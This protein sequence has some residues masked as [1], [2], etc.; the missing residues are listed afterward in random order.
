MSFGSTSQGLLTLRIAGE[1]D[2][3]LSRQRARQIASGLGFDEQDQT[4]IATAVSEIARNAWEYAHGGSVAFALEAAKP[5]QASKGPLFSVSI[6]DSGS[7]ILDLAGVLD[8]RFQSQTGMGLGLSGARR[9]MDHFDIESS[10]GGTVVVLG[11]FLPPGVPA[12]DG[13][14][15]AH[16]TSELSSQSPQSLLDEVQRQNQ[17][18][19]RTLEE[20]RARQEQ[21]VQLNAEL[22]DTNRGVVALYAEL[23][24]RADELRRANEIKTRFLRSMSHELRT[25]IN[26]ILGLVRLLGTEVDGTLSGEQQK[27]VAFIR[28]SGESL[29]EIV[30]DLLDL[31]KV[32]AGKVAIRPHSF[33]V[34]DLFGALR[35]MMK[36]LLDESESVRLVFEETPLSPMF[37]DE[38]K[39]SQILRN[40][41]SNA[42]KFTPR[43]EVR[44]SAR[45]LPNEFIEFCVEDSGIGLAPND[46][47]GV[48]DE[49]TQVETPLHARS[50]GTGLGLPLARRLAQLLGGSVSASSEAGVGSRFCVQVPRVYGGEAE[51]ELVFDSARDEAPSTATVIEEKEET[52]LVIDDDAVDRYLLRQMLGASRRVVE[53]RDGAE[54]LRLAREIGPRLIFLDLEMPGLNGAQVLQGLQEEP[55]TR[56]IPVVIHSSRILAEEEKR[57]LAG[58]ALAVLSKD[59]T[60]ESVV[61]LQEVLARAGLQPMI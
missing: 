46:L 57:D 60:P 21:L 37:T 20:L 58:R 16:I 9:L 6:R 48:W 55:Q 12:P 7:G 24:E 44:V 29:F 42:I 23:D 17:D 18:M 14:V 2:V 33:E 59:R 28:Q 3:V 15:L 4:R 51:G 31:A 49:F 19:L 45:V 10:A 1:G 5:G 35:G 34:D 36:P 13:Q 26:A 61:H 40:F 38:G 47:A 41:V 53:A 22:E 39:L 30:N 11:K 32:D 54:G 52:I 50:K 27:Q 43:G 8:G 56:A 25:P